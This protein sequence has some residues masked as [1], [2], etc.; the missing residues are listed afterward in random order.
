[1]F[2]LVIEPPI[3]W[4]GGVVRKAFAVAWSDHNSFLSFLRT[5]FTGLPI[6]SQL[7]LS[8][9]DQMQSLRAV[10]QTVTQHKVTSL[11]FFSHGNGFSEFLLRIG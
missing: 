7:K 6:T 1:M 10:N 11:F 9:V 2:H 5:N 8:S 3:K 4:N